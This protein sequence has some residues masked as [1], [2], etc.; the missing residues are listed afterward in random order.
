M[1]REGITNAGLN[2]KSYTLNPKPLNPKPTGLSLFSCRLKPEGGLEFWGFKAGFTGLRGEYVFR[3]VVSRSRVVHAWT[4]I[5]T[6][7]SIF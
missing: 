2:P 4:A 3:V 1:Q 7:P 6:E 5:E